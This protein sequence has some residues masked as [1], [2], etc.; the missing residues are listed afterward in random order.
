[1]YFK[2]EIKIIS[3]GQNSTIPSLQQIVLDTYDTEIY[4]QSFP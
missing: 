3:S 2:S 1:M 4:S